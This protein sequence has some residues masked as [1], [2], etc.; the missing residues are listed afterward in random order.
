MVAQHAV[1][2]TLPGLDEV[3]DRLTKATFDAV[4]STPYEAEVRRAEERVLVDRLTWLAAVAPAS[5]VRAVASFKL[6][7]IGAR[8][9][10]ADAAATDADQAQRALLAADITRFLERPAET[11]RMLPAAPAPPGAPIGDPGHDWLVP[12]PSCPWDSASPGTW[13]SRPPLE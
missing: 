7:Q 2:S 9:Q 1:D 8:L 12:P 6:R 3:V 5:Q 10:R 11:A 13:L 4:T